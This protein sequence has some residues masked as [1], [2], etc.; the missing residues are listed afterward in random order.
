VEGQNRILGVLSGEDM[1]LAQLERW[2]RSASFVIA[3]DG[4]ANRLASLGIAPDA[5]VGDM[6][7]IAPSVLSSLDSH[8]VDRDQSRTD[9][10]KLLA[11]AEAKG[12]EAITLTSVEGDLP[13][14]FL[15]T[16]QSAARSRLR[17]SFAL[18]QGLGYIVR[19]GETFSIKAAVGARVSL[20][21][22]L[23][24]DGVLLEG[25]EWPV[26]GTAM[27]PLGFTSISNRATAETVTV[28]LGTGAA[29]LF[30]ANQGS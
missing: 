12:F 7:S 25:V 5:V 1:P 20:L 10:D 3:A 8:F 30:V 17:V 28:A 19:G 27:D 15:A 29:F 13:D 6:D 21:P 16:L 11:L 18:R 4:G 24:C 22:L 23:A 2:V 9:C 26:L 14:H